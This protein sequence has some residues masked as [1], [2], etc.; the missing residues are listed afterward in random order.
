MK[1]EYQFD[2]FISHSGKDEAIAIDVYN[3]LTSQGMRCWLDHFHIPP[4]SQA[5]AQ[6][7]VCGIEESEKFLILY[8]KNVVGS[9]DIPNEINMAKDKPLYVFKLDDSP[10]GGEY[11]YY[12]SRPQYIKAYPNY[13]KHLPD[14]YAYLQTDPYA[15][16]SSGPNTPKPK[17]KWGWV[18]LVIALLMA[19]LGLGYKYLPVSTA[20]LRGGMDAD[21]TQ[22]TTDTISDS[23]APVVIKQADNHSGNP[24]NPKDVAPKK[25]QPNTQPVVKQQPKQPI[26]KSYT[27]NGVTFRM[28]KVNAGQFAMGADASTDSFAYPEEA[29]IHSVQLTDFYIGETEVTQALWTAVMGAGMEE[30][31]KG[32]KAHGLGNE[33]PMYYVSYDDCVAF[34]MALNELTGESF[35]LPTEAEWEYAAR[36]RTSTQLYA[37]AN[38]IGGVA[39]Y[40][41][42]S[43]GTTQPVAQKKANA[44]GLY[45]MCGNVAE[46]C[47]DWFELYP[48]EA[49]TNPLGPELGE[50]KVFRG[51]S[52]ADKAI[53]CRVSCRT[54]WQPD[55]RSANIGLRLAL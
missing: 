1:K 24:S 49:S 52:W 11:K 19:V 55:Y 44:L 20:Y 21:T 17:K 2:V 35:R 46:W 3:Y 29:P 37:G 23:S 38:V 31:I 8:S 32:K 6:C 12:L 10:Y 54:A 53:D 48:D 4:A 43:G 50:L 15:H 5:Y 28:M 13:K 40:E 25:E 36:E 14:L 34:V 18:V 7:I 41:G 47:M 16:A 51:G 39:W 22:L 27:V 42:N 26:A 9:S 30:Y 45:D 33:Y